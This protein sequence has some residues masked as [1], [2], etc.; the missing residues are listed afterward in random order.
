MK[1]ARLLLVIAL[2]VA[3]LGA[4]P[5]SASAQ[6][7]FSYVSTINIQNLQ[8]TA[9]TVTFNYYSGSGGANPGT[10]INTVNAPIGAN[11]FKAF[12][13]LDVASGFSGSVVLSSNV[14]I[15]AVSNI[16][17]NNMAANASYIG[18]SAGSTSLYI[19]LL[20]KGNFGY[21]TWFNVQNAGSADATVSVAYS[22]QTTA[23]ATIKPNASHTFNQAT[24]THGNGVRQ[25]FS[26]IV[27]ST[28]SQPILAVVV[29]ESSQ[30]LFAYGGF[31]SASVSPTMPLINTNNFGYTTSVQIQN[32]G[33]AATDV[34]V[35]Y[36]P[37]KAGTACTET[38]NVPAGQSKTFA[39]N[40]FTNSG[41][42]VTTTCTKGQT[43][44]G[45]ASV[46][47]NS[48]SQNLVTVVNQ[49]RL[50]INGDAYGG[51]DTSKATNSLVLPLLMDRNYGWF[52][53]ANIMN[54]G[55]API[56]LVCTL[57]NTTVKID[58]DNLA[59]GAMVN[60]EQLNKIANA[61]T[62]S[63]SCNAYN[64]G[65]TTVNAAHKIV[66]VVNELK[67]GSQ[68]TFMVYPG[69]NVGP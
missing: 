63:A 16:H 33:N 26:A 21:D 39:T 57:T 42:T 35:S 61:W 59:P 53:S 62:G 8:N 67:S 36:S 1:S 10:L 50:P 54:V 15:A 46:T 52:T 45:S 29:E 64:A 55:T 47:T 30:V 17:G 5:G 4:I 31:G 32:V 2:M 60:D 6:Y 24:E 3:V 68:D 9:G 20:M 14:Q 66:G 27:T 69:I 19:P 40:A 51:F 38:Q 7:K 49:H 22:D 43:F 65:T 48:A 37:S 34:T 44:V 56:H 23:T 13:S 18:Q 12:T 11:E 41:V 28:N 25:V 58:V